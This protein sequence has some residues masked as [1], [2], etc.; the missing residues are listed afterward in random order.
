MRYTRFIYLLSQRRPNTTA[1]PIHLTRGMPEL[2]VPLHVSY[3]QNLG[4]ASV[5]VQPFLL[6]LMNW[7]NNPEQR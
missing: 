7:H 2:Q 4:N 1:T 3:I 5:F 6:H